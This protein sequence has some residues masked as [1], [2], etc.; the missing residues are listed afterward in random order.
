MGSSTAE[1]VQTELATHSRSITEQ[2]LELAVRVA[3]LELRKV[4][5]HPA[6]KIAKPARKKK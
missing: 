2:V 5:K 3:A 1:K 6:K 4:H